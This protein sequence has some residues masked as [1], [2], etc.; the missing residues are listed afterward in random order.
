[1]FK[2]VFVFESEFYLGNSINQSYS[3]VTVAVNASVR[4]KLS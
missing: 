3:N 2:S 4:G 1:M